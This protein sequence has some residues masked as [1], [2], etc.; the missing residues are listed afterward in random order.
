MADDDRYVPI[1]VR[2]QL[3]GIKAFEIDSKISQ[4]VPRS[5]A[6][7]TPVGLETMSGFH[8][9]IPRTNIPCANKSAT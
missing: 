8:I 4:G 1:A 9:R 3:I 2:P 5:T 7:L 6:H